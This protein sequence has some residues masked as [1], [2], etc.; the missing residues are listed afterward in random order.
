M[1]YNATAMA[2]D[3][4]GMPARRQWRHHAMPSCRHCSRF[5]Q[6]L[7]IMGTTGGKLHY[8]CRGNQHLR[9]MKTLTIESRF[10]VCSIDELT[11]AE[12]RLVECARRATGHSYAPYSSFHVGAAVMLADGT[13]VEGS[14]QE[15]ASYPAGTCA[16][17]T[18]IFYANSAY[19]DTPVTMLAVAARAGDTFTAG[20]VPPCGVCRQVLWEFAPDLEVLLYNRRGEIKVLPLRQLLPYSFDSSSLKG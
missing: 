7:H 20:P 9:Q 12:R 13:I 15:N 14:N 16:E 4:A 8:I 5:A 19:P 18:A 1:A 3:P 2:Y 6:S 10:A 11:D 17:R